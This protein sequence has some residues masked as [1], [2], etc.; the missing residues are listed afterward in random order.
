MATFLTPDK[1]KTYTIGNESIK[2][3]EKIIPDSMVAKK[4]VASW[5]KKGQ[6]MK[7]CAKLNNGT[8]KPKGIT[9]HN[10]ND[11]KVANGTDAAEQY[12]RSTFN[13]HMSGVVVHY[14]VWHD[15]VWQTLDNTERGW[16]AADGSSRRQDHKGGMTGGNLDTIALEVIGKDIESETTAAKLVAYLC[17]TYGLDPKYDVYTH[18]FWM[19]GGDKKYSGVRKNCPE[20]ILPHWSDFLIRINKYYS[21]ANQPAQSASKTIYRVQVGAYA[22][23]ANAVAM[24]ERLIKDGYINSYIVMTNGLFKVQ[25]GAYGIKSNAT[26]K[27][28][29]LK[30]KGYA[31][32]IVT[33]Q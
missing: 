7:P 24:K 14:Y 11:I 12:T 20:Y 9:V 18:N 26:A 25:V 32:Y 27:A 10:T 16:H 30:K 28:D 29:E 3:N 31:T 2:I 23:K 22:K 19:Y 1:V 6:K 8:G 4:D 5:C 13:E 15:R 17:K 33:K 21:A